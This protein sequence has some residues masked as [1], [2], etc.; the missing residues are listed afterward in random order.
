MLANPRF[1]RNSPLFDGAA[2]VAT[3]SVADAT[4]TDVLLWAK[5]FMVI[6]AA[7]S[8]AAILFEKYI[9]SLLNLFLLIYELNIVNLHPAVGTTA[10]V[11]TIA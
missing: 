9:W 7:K 10:E 1:C 5:P 6:V 3:L 2:D 11:I 8:N 4:A